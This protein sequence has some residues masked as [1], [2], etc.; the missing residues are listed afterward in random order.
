MTDATASAG[1][2][3]WA[4]TILWPC[5]HLPYRS[6][7]R[8]K[9]YARLPEDYRTWSAL[10]L[11]VVFIGALASGRSGTSSAPAVLMHPIVPWL[12]FALVA[13]SVGVFLR[14]RALKVAWS[15]SDKTPTQQLSSWREKWTTVER[16]SEHFKS[17]FASMPKEFALANAW[18]S[19]PTFP[20]LTRLLLAPVPA[21][22][23]Y[24][25]VRPVT[26]TFA[27]DGTD[28]HL[29]SVRAAILLALSRVGGQS[30][31]GRA[32][33]HIVA[34]FMFPDVVPTQ[35]WTFVSVEKTSSAINVTAEAGLMWW[36]RAGTEM[37]DGKTLHGDLPLYGLP[38]FWRQFRMKPLALLLLLV[39]GFIVGGMSHYAVM[40]ALAAFLVLVYFAWTRP[41][42]ERRIRSGLTPDFGD[43]LDSTLLSA[44]RQFGVLEKV[45][46]NAATLE[47]LK[48]LDQEVTLALNAAGYEPS[49]NQAQ[50]S[51]TRE[52]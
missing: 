39:G 15:T 16:E 11:A 52:D 24:T 5:Q 44:E 41:A 6:T 29:R 14:H 1:D 36:A 17:S 4:K 7:V 27:S 35:Y 48:A 47:R 19:A 46:P 50:S 42:E 25:V 3:S 22:G 51:P 26:R 13:W 30:V 21:N 40:V 8:A 37:M 28:E 9:F 10:L 20:P 32:G 34:T 45:G 2:S 12:L 23:P 49:P 43:S 33:N 18:E 31:V 38:R